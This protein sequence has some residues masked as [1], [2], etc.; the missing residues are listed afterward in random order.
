MVIRGLVIIDDFWMNVE[1]PMNDV[2][3]LLD[4]SESSADRCGS[5]VTQGGVPTHCVTLAALWHVGHLSIILLVL[6]H[7]YVSHMTLSG[8]SCLRVNISLSKE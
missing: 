8:S 7:C 6:V 1:E 4:G 3:A 2:L 5:S